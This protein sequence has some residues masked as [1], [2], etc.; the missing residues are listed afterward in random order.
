MLALSTYLPNR[1]VLHF[2]PGVAER[3]EITG[4]LSEFFIFVEEIPRCP[5]V[6]PKVSE[7]GGVIYCVL[8]VCR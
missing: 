5:F 7:R 3:N 2:I 6:T 8:S 4:N 1:L